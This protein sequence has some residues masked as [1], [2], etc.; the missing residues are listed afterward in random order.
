MFNSDLSAMIFLSLL[1]NQCATVWQKM[2]SNYQEE[3]EEYREKLTVV[4]N[5]YAVF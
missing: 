2:H 5:F 1:V 4:A 3:R